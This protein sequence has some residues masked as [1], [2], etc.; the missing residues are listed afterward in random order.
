MTNS[1]PE[2][3]QHAVCF[4]QGLRPS[5]V[6]IVALSVV[7]G[8]HQPPVA[9]DIVKDLPEMDFGMRAE[10]HLLQNVFM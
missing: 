9:G 1:L 7:A 8:L 2:V 5:E 6:R 4:V 10:G 3:H